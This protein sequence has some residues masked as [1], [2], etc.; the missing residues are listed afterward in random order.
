MAA[1]QSMQELQ[2][3]LHATTK[4]LKQI[5]SHAL[6]DDL[7]VAISELALNVLHNSGLNIG[8]ADVYKLKKYK[9]F[10][11]ILSDPNETLARKKSII[12]SKAYKFLPALLKLAIPHVPGNDIDST[13]GMETAQE[14]ATTSAHH[15]PSAHKPHKRRAPPIGSRGRKVARH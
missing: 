13:G 6:S 12:K 1:A 14:P 7:I 3:L 8:V 15:D 4:V 10:L 5:L 2:V 11:T 9:K